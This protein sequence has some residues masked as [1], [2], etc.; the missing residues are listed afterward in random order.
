MKLLILD[1]E[2][3]GTKEKC[4]NLV[5]CAATV[6]DGEKVIEEQDWWLHKDEAQQRH[7]RLFLERHQDAVIVAFGA[8]AEASSIISLG[9]DPLKWKWVCLHLEYRCLQNHSHELMH[10]LQ[11]IDGEVVRTYPFGEKGKQNL[12]AATYKLLGE[13]IDT[14]EKNEV[15]ELIISSPADFSPE[16][17]TRILDYGRSDVKYLHKL[18]KKMVALY[19]RRDPANK[20]LLKEMFWRGEYAVRTA[21]MVRLGYPVD[22]KWLKNFADNAPI[23]LQECSRDINSQV[24]LAPFHWLKKEQ[25]FALRQKVVQ[26]WIHQKHPEGWMLTDTG[27]YSLALEAFESKYSFR[28][29]Y[30]RGHLGAQMLRFLRLQQ[31]LRGY[32][33]HAKK[34]IFNDLGADGRVRAYLNPYGAQSSR[35]QPAST[36]FIFL[37]PAFQR[38]LVRPPKGRCI[39][40]LD[41]SSEEFLL[42]ALMSGDQKMID[43]YKS[44][45]VYLAFGKA[46]GWIPKNGTKKTHKFQRDVCK[47]VVLSISYLMGAEGLAARLTEETGKEFTVEKAQELISLFNETYETFDEFR[48]ELLRDYNDKGH[49]KLKDGWY[50]WGDNPNFRSISNAPIQGAGACIMRRAVANAQ[51]AGLNVI[52]TLHDAIYI[53]YEAGDYGALDTLKSCMDDAFVNFFD[54][55]MKQE[56]KAIRVDPQTWGSGFREPTIEDGEVKYHSITTPAGMKVPSSSYFIDPR[57]AREFDKFKD[58][59]FQSSGQDLLE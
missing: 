34:S 43:A 2:F 14:K 28:H 42:G 19:K 5:S 47:A 25:R 58:Y 4:L 21:K 26:D 52:F 10:G 6:Y 8:E 45:D 41:W 53:D 18:L 33:P 17:I 15:R 27:K 35:T 24:P 40:D 12:G 50:M 56:A 54:G 30:P 46:I 29:D 55:K 59:M 57:A 23:V 31:S 7:H 48:K 37:K 36:G 3:N 49:M 38:T 20:T 39:G 13:V 44:G 22:V 1:Y 16:Q 51:D 32:N 9:L 11:L